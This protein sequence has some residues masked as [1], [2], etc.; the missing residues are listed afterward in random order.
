MS[1]PRRPILYPRSRRRAINGGPGHKDWYNAVQDI[2]P[3]MMESR[4]KSWSPADINLQQDCPFYNGRIPREITDLIFEYALSPDTLPDPQCELGPGHD[5]RVRYDHERSDDES[6][7]GS[8]PQQ[9]TAVEATTSSESADSHVVIDESLT[10]SPISRERNSGF[11]WFRPE[12]TG[13]KLFRGCE[14][15]RTCRR[16]YLDTNKLLEQARDVVI[17]GGREPPWG[18][19]FRAFINQ[20]RRGYKQQLPKITS[21]RYFVQMYRLISAQQL[22]LFRPC[23]EALA[24]YEPDE[25]AELVTQLT[26]GNSP[27]EPAWRVLYHLEH[28]HM[29]IR[30][31]DWDRWEDN[32]ALAINPY[33]YSMGPASLELMRHDMRASMVKGNQSDHEHSPTWSKMFQAMRNLKTLTISFETSEDKKDEMEE[34]VAWAKTWRFDIMSWRHWTRDRINERAACLV[35]EDK[36]A[37]KMSWRGLKH[38]WSDFCTSCG[39]NEMTRSDCACCLEKRKLLQQNKGPRLLVWTL[40]WRPEPVEMPR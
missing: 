10:I 38:H 33:R 24:G 6:D 25:L 12:N 8:V 27:T 20:L 22:T 11:D 7:L 9:V 3:T 28:F 26:Q 36:P 18:R 32:K 4:L 40:T 19:D 1:L 23:N 29:T 5:F 35:A 15:L 13:R 34:I 21:I 37:R 30:R 16:L 17:Y 39:A 2:L 31:T 14:L